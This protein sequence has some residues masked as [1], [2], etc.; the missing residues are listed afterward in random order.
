M[1]ISAG[2][3][4]SASS[5]N[6]FLSAALGLVGEAKAAVGT[7]PRLFR[8]LLL[9]SLRLVSLSPNGSMADT[10][11]SSLPCAEEETRADSANQTLITRNREGEEGRR[12]L[13]LGGWLTKS[14]AVFGCLQSAKN[15][16]EKC[17]TTVQQ[18]HRWSPSRSRA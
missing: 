2:S 3:W 6:L 15:P 4:F 18:I 10:D 14:S 9:A 8:L 13:G 1:V 17:K 11:R 5:W 12:T 16:N 7:A